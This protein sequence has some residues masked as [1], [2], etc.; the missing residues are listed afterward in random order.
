MRAPRGQRC[1]PHRLGSHPKHS[2]EETPRR[3]RLSCSTTILRATAR[4]L[5]MAGASASRR[6]RALSRGRQR[7]QL[8]APRCPSRRDRGDLRHLGH[9]ASV[10][11]STRLH[12]GLHQE[13]RRRRAP[14]SSVPSWSMNS[15]GSLRLLGSFG[16]LVA[17]QDGPVA[18]DTG[19]PCRAR[20]RALPAAIQVRL[21]RRDLGF[22]WSPAPLGFLWFSIHVDSFAATPAVPLGWKHEL[23]GARM[24]RVRHRAKLAGR[25]PSPRAPS[26]LPGDR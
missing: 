21:S 10:G 3:S 15:P 1:V 8:R 17:S 18:R 9:A 13:R 5:P 25:D 22:S 14:G 7:G 23:A 26:A 2:R 24:W 20:H 4:S 11:R 16:F 19:A 6:Y 12:A